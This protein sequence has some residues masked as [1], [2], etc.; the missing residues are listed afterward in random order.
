M[1][2]RYVT[3]AGG[4]SHVGNTPEN[5]FTLS[6][7]FMYVNNYGALTDP[8][9]FY[10]CGNMNPTSAVLTSNVVNGTTYT[11][12][13]PPMR[14][15]ATRTNRIIF[16]G[17]T[18]DG[19]ADADIVIDCVNM[20]TTDVI[21]PNPNNINTP[22]AGGGL[23]CIFSCI[24]DVCDWFV[25]R[26]LGVYNY[27]PEVL[28]FN[29]QAT[30]FQ[31]RNP[32]G[33]VQYYRCKSVGNTAR[34]FYV[35][36]R[37]MILQEC[38]ASGNKN[39]TDGTS[40]GVELI[41]PAESTADDTGSLAIE[42][43]VDDNIGAGFRDRGLFQ[44][45][46]IGWNH[47]GTNVNADFGN[48]TW[49]TDQTDSCTYELSNRHAIKITGVGGAMSKP[50]TIFNTLATSSQSA[51]AFFFNDDG[52][53]V[54]IRAADWNNST[55]RFGTITQAMPVDIDDPD[56]LSDPYVNR[57]GGDFTLNNNPTGGLRCQET[58]G[59]PFMGTETVSCHDIGAIQHFCEEAEEDIV[60]PPSQGFGWGL[61]HIAARIIRGGKVRK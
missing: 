15:A 9:L 58:E 34:G 25:F 29:K 59:I 50:A 11:N 51:S 5:A 48:N 16:Q 27:R 47:V 13:F 36:C 31:F 14:K 26:N 22:A 33:N 54:F 6:E 8:I 55:G 56:V 10:L 40:W 42:C 41:S 61:E 53:N 19:T 37:N 2:I 38:R 32:T 3:N 4:G 43:V 35:D 45:R 57:A 28:A 60:I 23:A 1:D 12:R 39:D 18:S 30:G 24:G 46:C 7:A 21:V 20:P 49:R 52:L 44:H 17:R